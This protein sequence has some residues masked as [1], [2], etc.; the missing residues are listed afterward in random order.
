LKSN[1]SLAI[2][3]CSIYLL[4]LIIRIG[5]ICYTY[6]SPQLGL[7]YQIGEAARNLSSGRGYVVD[8]EY[9]A[10]I[11]DRMYKTNRLV[12]MQDVPPPDKESFTPYYGLPPGTSSLV[13]LTF[14]LSGEYRYIYERILQAIID[15][16]GCFIMFLLCRELFTRRVG[17]IASFIY[18]IFLPIAALSTFVIHDALM[19][20]FILVSLYFF[21]KGV[22]QDKLLFYLLSS[23]FIGISCYFQPTALFLPCLYGLA[24]LIYKFRKHEFGRQFVNTI[25]ITAAMLLIVMTM[26]LPWIMRNYY[27][28]GI[29]SP[30][31][32]VGT[33]AGIWQGFGEFADNPA[34]AVLDDVY[35]WELAKKE[36]GYDVKFGSPEYDLVF[37]NKVI[38]TISEH[39]LWWLKALA[40]RFPRTIFYY[41][42]LGIQPLC[43]DY[44]N[45]SECQNSQ[46]TWVNFLSAWNNGT[47]LQTVIKYP[48]EAFYWGLAAAF[49]ILPVLFSAAGIW[50]IRKDWRKV[51]LII[52]PAVY[53]SAVH[54]VCFVSGVGKSLL[55]GS[56][57]YLIL[58]AVFINYLLN[59]MKLPDNED[60]ATS[61]S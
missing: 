13:A 44:Q 27:V 61:S 36:L 43:P 37:K 59:R 4:A 50:I 38:N 48:Y 58:S 30:N 1:K 55:P 12:E 26:T 49:A 21:V 51:I 10:I 52:T 46:V 6:N 18:A 35:A 45:W 5:I 22:L 23:L 39:P 28:T 20:F 41:S 14:S 60:L 40:L 29:L 56:I 33:W 11:I 9:I 42:G 3:L 31:M 8:D 32:R 47:F 7:T 19:P 24:L 53:L 17:L 2:I 57:A 54:M 15:S 34:G 25:K 16:F